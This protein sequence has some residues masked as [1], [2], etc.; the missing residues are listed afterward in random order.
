MRST[1]VDDAVTPVFTDAFPDG[2]RMQLTGTLRHQRDQYLI[3]RQL[4]RDAGDG[5][6]WTTPRVHRILAIDTTAD[7]LRAHIDQVV[8][9]TGRV[10]RGDARNRTAIIVDQVQPLE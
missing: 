6:R 3:E 7:A 5:P 4:T 10:G 8:T 1:T 9:I 2:A